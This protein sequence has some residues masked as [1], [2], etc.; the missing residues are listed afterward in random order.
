[1][2]SGSARDARCGI[3]LG[4]YEEE[5]YLRLGE[6]DHAFHRDCLDVR[7]LPCCGTGLTATQPWL[8]ERGSCP[9]CRKVVQ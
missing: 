2:A 1:M 4:D 7:T 9:L 6:C 3:C 8:K 5:D